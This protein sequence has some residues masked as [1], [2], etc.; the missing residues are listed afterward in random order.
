[1]RASLAA[2]AADAEDAV[3]PLPAGPRS[4]LGAT[5]RYLRDPFAIMLDAGERYGDPFTWPTFYGRV[6]VT[7]DPV[8]IKE[9]LTADP[10]IYSAIG[11]DLLGPVLGPNNLI[12][13]SGAPHRAMRRFYGPPMNGEAL[14]GY[15][16]VITRIAAEHVARW[17]VDRPFAVEDTMREI[18]LD[19]IL[20]VV[21]GLGERGARAEFKGAI[22]QL[23]RSLKPSFMFIPALR[24]SLLGLGA[25]ARF[26]RRATAAAALFERELAARRAAARPKDDLLSLLMAARKGD[27]S[28][29]SSEEIMEQMVSLIGAGHETT[30]SALTWALFHIHRSPSVKERLL[31]ELRGLGEQLDPAAVTR[32][33]FL[34]AVCSEV[35]R[36]EPVAPLIGRTLRSDLTLKGHTVPA[37]LSVGI[38]IIGL[39]RRPDLYPEPDQFSPERFLGRD[40]GPFEYIP[41]GGGSRRCLGASFAIYEMK[42]VLATV[43]RGQALRL[44]DR[45]D[46]RA[47]AR[48]TTASPARKIEL[49]HVR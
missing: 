15:G 32:L 48:N 22:L 2:R 25:W 34:D 47:V 30:G 44:T 8:G 28:A 31:D 40:Y 33:P 13:L 18:S 43:L 42:L 19:V 10:A 7:S 45:R 37:G 21:L 6:V 11:A 16:A 38:S 26:R 9:I 49:C 41:F 12:L 1:M 23:V 17:P 3:M 4:A 39:H 27:G 29:F 14:H 20:E 35:L 36:L 24:R 46:V 5:A